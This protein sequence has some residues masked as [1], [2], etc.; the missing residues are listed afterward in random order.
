MSAPS[1]NP[2]T[3]TPLTPA[4]VSSALEAPVSNLSAAIKSLLPRLSAPLV[5]TGP[6]LGST[7]LKAIVI[8]SSYLIHSASNK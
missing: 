3:P 7:P 6:T 8:S 4:V 5:A 2:A 1:C